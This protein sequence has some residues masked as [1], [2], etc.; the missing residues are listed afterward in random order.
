GFDLVFCS[1]VLYYL[2]R[3]TRLEHVAQRIA[4]LVEPGGLLVL[5]HSRPQA[6]LL[7]RYFNSRPE[8]RPVKEFTNDFQGRSYTVALYEHAFLRDAA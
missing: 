4:S 8:L 2:G 7:H 6:R 5:V 1:E 3:S